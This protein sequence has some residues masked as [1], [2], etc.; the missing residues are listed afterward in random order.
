V[1][2]QCYENGLLV[3]PGTGTVDGVK[4]DHIQVAPPLVVSIEEI[5]EVVG[6]LDKSISEVEEKVL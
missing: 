2:E 5:D 1:V 4:G 6:L 3:Y